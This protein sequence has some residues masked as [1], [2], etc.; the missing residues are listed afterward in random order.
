MA[1][2]KALRRTLVVP[3]FL[4]MESQSAP[5][6]HWF[7]ASHFFDLRGMARSQPIIELRDF[8]ALVN[9]SRS[10][11]GAL[12]S[13]LYPPYLLPASAPQYSGAFFRQH[14]IRFDGPR[15]IS[16]FH[17]AKQASSGRS[18]EPYRAGEGLGYWR[19]AA[20]HLPRQ[21]REMRARHD[22]M[23]R[24]GEPAGQSEEELGRSPLVALVGAHSKQIEDWRGVARDHPEV[25]GE[26]EAGREA[27][28]DAAAAPDTL[29]LDF[30]PSYNFAVDD[31]E[32]DRELVTVQR[33]TPFHPRLHALA[34][35]A[36]A[37]L[38]AAPSAGYVAAHLRRDGYQGYCSGAGLG[39]YGGRR[40]GVSVSAEMCYPSVQQAA[41]AIRQAI[42]RHSAG[43]S[44][45]LPRPAS[46]GARSVLLATNSIDAA[47]ID[48]LRLEL[49][50][51]AREVALLRWAPP[52]ALLRESPELVPAV[53]MLLCARAELFVGTLPSTF[54][55]TILVQR[56]ALGRPRNTTSFFGAARFFP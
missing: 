27:A 29:A 14:G 48:E 42:D 17:E 55:A 46:G 47:E 33:A 10:G 53:E 6:Q 39:H 4:W 45:G 15:L 18:D 26:V 7:A 19:A 25:E 24:R 9:S 49:A 22:E 51:G 11:G 23:V 16:P 52:P 50:R 34:D 12:G 8:A 28:R 3:P 2:A 40:Y 54:S 20:L 1:V 41:A 36:V 35:A 43:L 38:F 44:A 32:F 31:F 30:A 21:Q 56:D 37:S 5:T 13:Y